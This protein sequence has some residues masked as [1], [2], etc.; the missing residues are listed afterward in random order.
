M[1]ILNSRTDLIQYSLRKLGAPVIKIDVAESQIND[2]V[3]DAIQYWQ[4]YATDGIKR[5]YFRHQL[6]DQDITNGYISLNDTLIIS[7]ERIFPFDTGTNNIFSY[8]YQFF[9]NDV[10]ALGGSNGLGLVNYDIMRNE[11]ALLDF[12][13]QNGNIIRFNRHEN[14]VYLDTDP[15]QLV[16]GSWIVL[17]CHRAIDMASFK[18]TFNDVFLK[19]YV[20]ALI[21]KIW[22][23]NLKKFS[24][25]QLAG[26]V[27]LNGQQIYDEAVG[28]IE[29]LEDRLRNEWNEPL[30]FITG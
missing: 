27:T 5:F 7:V 4:N 28:E 17:E 13:F 16:A 10:Y 9:Q 29:K 2:A 11:I 21:K 8:K 26:Q 25:V 24:G 23:S 3:D 30:Y 6:T 19:A 14:L 18:D 15:G 1:P 12:L 22:G 20:P